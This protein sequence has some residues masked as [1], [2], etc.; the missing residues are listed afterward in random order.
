MK[1]HKFP[2]KIA[3][4]FAKQILEGLRHIHKCNYVHLDLK[5]ENIM[6]NE[7]YKPVIIDFGFARKFNGT[8]QFLSY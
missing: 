3:R 7:E 8:K 5:L 1:K 6:L 2:E 4:F